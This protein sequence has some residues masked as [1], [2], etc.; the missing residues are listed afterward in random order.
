MEVLLRGLEGPAGVGGFGVQGVLITKPLLK[1]VYLLLTA[2][3]VLQIGFDAS[4][5]SKVWGLRSWV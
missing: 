1:R 4:G 3:I 5:L 2:V